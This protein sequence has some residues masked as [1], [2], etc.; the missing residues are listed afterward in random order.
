MF[1]HSS[2]VHI[3]ADAGFI[4]EGSESGAVELALAAE[5]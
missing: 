4:G 3:L 1:F 5:G 2:L